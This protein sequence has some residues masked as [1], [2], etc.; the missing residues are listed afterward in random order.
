MR[1]TIPLDVAGKWDA[2]DSETVETSPASGVNPS[3]A[4]P[5][6]QLPGL[7][8]NVVSGCPASTT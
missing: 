2:G 3:I 6:V 7:A 5:A 4:S 1:R 8:V